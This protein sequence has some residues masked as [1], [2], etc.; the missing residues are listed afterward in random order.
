[1]KKLAEEGCV[2]LLGEKKSLQL[3]SNE[4]SLQQHF[5]LQMEKKRTT[6]PFSGSSLLQSD[7]LVFYP[8]FCFSHIFLTI[9]LE[10]QGNYLC[11]AQQLNLNKTL[12]K[13]YLKSMLCVKGIPDVR[14]LRQ[15]S[16]VPFVL[17]PGCLCKDSPISPFV[18]GDPLKLE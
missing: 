11:P 6:S 7:F 17:E 3:L 14:A 16:S 1:M 10:P 8:H 18:Q 5:L 9:Q 12:G 4:Q 15:P 13:V 2:P